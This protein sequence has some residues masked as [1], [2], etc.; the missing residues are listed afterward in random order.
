MTL[1]CIIPAVEFK[2]ERV[3]EEEVKQVDNLRLG[4]LDGL[5][6]TVARGVIYHVL[7]SRQWPC[8]AQS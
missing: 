8:I 3:N 6:G 4:G 2:K 7:R 5:I 1:N